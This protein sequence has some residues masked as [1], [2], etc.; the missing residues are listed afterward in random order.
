M[1]MIRMP[2]VFQ[3]GIV[4]PRDR[5]LDR[6]R[7]ADGW[8]RV[9]VVVGT[10][11]DETKLFLFGSPVWVRR[12]LGFLPRLRDPERYDAV[13]EHTSAMWKA[14]GADEVA[15]AMHASGT[16]D[17][18][19]YRFDW[20]EQPAPLGTDLPRML[21]AA[22]GL[23]IP[24]VFDHFD[25]GREGNRLFTADNEPG[26]RALAE[27]MGMHWTT[28]AATGHPGAEWPA[29]GSPGTFVVFDTPAGGGVRPSPE[30]VAP[31]LVMA[32]IAADPRLRD[33]REKCLA[34]HDLL[35][36]SAS[37]TRAAYDA[38]CPRLP[39]EGYPWAD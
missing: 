4:L 36:W 10:T 9:P 19:V 35:V 14:N 33:T 26:R 11:R 24:F 3:D 1:G 8:N 7:R 29:W 13:A 2:M 31:D 16:S 5:H 32:R 22:H 21:G 18:W 39:P 12:W 27:A 23:E 20:D 25:L 38:N 6:F 28:F 15:R 30:T 17:V 34:Y 37:I